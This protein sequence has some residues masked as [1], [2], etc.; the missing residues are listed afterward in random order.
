MTQ[1]TPCLICERRVHPNRTRNVCGAAVCD[2]CEV[3]NMEN[4]WH[5]R[6]GRLVYDMSTATG[7]RDQASVSTQ[8]MLEGRTD[9]PGELQ[10]KLTREGLGKK[11]GKLFGKKELQVDDPLFD[12]LVHVS[13]APG[14]RPLAAEFLSHEGV[15]SVIMELVSMGGQLWIRGAEFKSDGV[16]NRM[17]NP[18]ELGLLGSVLLTHL[19]RFAQNGGRWDDQV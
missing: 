4:L 16:S 12:D 6:G 14:Q 13:V 5:H 18:Q 10:L 8:W 2:Q 9:V 1:T 11:L 17:L 3:S 7:G 19:Q 15:L